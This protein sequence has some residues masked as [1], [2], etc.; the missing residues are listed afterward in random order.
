MSNEEACP[1]ARSN[2]VDARPRNDLNGSLFTWRSTS[3]CVNSSAAG[4]LSCSSSLLLLLPAPAPAPA[5]APGTAA[6]FASDEGSPPAPTSSAPAS[7]FAAGATWVY[8]IEARVIAHHDGGGG[9]VTYCNGLWLWRHP[10]IGLALH[11]ERLHRWAH[12][13]HLHHS[14]LLHAAQRPTVSMVGHMSQQK[15]PSA[16]SKA[17][18]ISTRAAGAKQPRHSQRSPPAPGYP[19]VPCRRHWLPPRSRSTWTA[20]L[21]RVQSSA[22]C[23][24]TRRN[25]PLH[26]WPGPAVVWRRRAQQQAL[27]GQELDLVQVVQHCTRMDTHTHTRTPPAQ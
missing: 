15:P 13:G 11:G 6:P 17:P 18:G 2:T 3:S 1:R 7:P 8:Q 26:C 21:H 5:P 23:L 12:D 25:Q 20:L 4:V 27:P 9:G 10:R 14:T 22:N 24:G 19:L 16:P